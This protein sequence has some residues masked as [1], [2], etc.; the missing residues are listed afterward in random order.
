M[1]P[2]ATAVRFYRPPPRYE[3]GRDVMAET[4]RKVADALREAGV[5]L[6]DSAEE[7][8]VLLTWNVKT[9]SQNM[10]AWMASADVVHCYQS[11][12]QSGHLAMPRKTAKHRSISIITSALTRPKGVPIF[13]RFTVTDLSTITC[14]GVLSPFSASG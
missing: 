8:G 4:L 10:Q 1:I 7:R 2:M 5:S 6:I 3:A 9:V 11:L 12:F 13:S 14:E